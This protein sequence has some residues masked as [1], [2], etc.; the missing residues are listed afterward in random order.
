M[1]TAFISSFKKKTTK[2][3]K[4]KE[5]YQPVKSTSICISHSSATTWNLPFLWCL[6]F[7]VT[8]QPNKRALPSLKGKVTIR[9]YLDQKID[10]PTREKSN[11]ILAV[12]TNKQKIN[13]S[14]FTFYWIFFLFVFNFNIS[15]F[16][17]L[18]FILVATFFLC[19]KSKEVKS[20]KRQKK[21]KKKEEIFALIECASV[22]IELGSSIRHR[23]AL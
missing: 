15:L 2:K 20:R 4:V 6:P 9:P 12:E 22:V 14:V 23:E 3:R 5:R 21:E 19:V 7:R 1:T 8:C 18:F 17:H 11:V 10:W 16:Y 13:L